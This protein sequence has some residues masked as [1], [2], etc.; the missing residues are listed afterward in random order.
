MDF[1][2][3]G[4]GLAGSLLGYELLK[5]NKQVLIIDEEKINTSSKIAAGIILPITGRRIVKTWR[6]DEL[7]PF[8]ESYYRKI[9]NELQETFFQSLPILE[10][11]SSVKN[12]NDWL[13]RST[14][15]GFNKYIS[16][17]ISA[18]ELSGDLKTHDGGILLKNSGYVNI[19]KLVAACQTYFKSKN[20]FEAARFSEDEIEIT[21]QG[22]SWKD[23]KSSKIIFC[24]GYAAAKSRF[25]KGISF[26]PAKGEILKI[27]SQ[28][29]REDFIINHGMY[30]LPIGNHEFKVGATFKWNFADDLPSPEGRNEIESFLKNILNV[31]FEVLSHES[32]IRP[33][34]QDRRPIIGL[35]PEHA[36]VGIFNGLGT[37][38]ALLAPFF[39]RQFAEFLC[40][41][42]EMDA[43]VNMQRFYLG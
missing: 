7:L 6:A 28:E 41:G 1:I 4:Q 26:L 18:A 17:E 2:I 3:V 25:F 32:A 10:I 30:I 42:K 43:E 14:E 24:N 13:N 29:L 5:R 8:A 22:I 11:F 23:H 37:K 36:S 15:N 19:N 27:F 21:S 20:I 38:G 31:K 34:V 12:R 33:T 40:D 16:E 35:H 39:A 9:E